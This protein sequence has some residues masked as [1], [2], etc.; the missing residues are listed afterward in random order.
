MDWLTVVVNLVSGTFAGT[1]ASFIATR[2]IERLKAD[3]N[4]EL[5]ESQNRFSIGVNSHQAQIGFDKRAEF[6]ERYMEEALR[7]LNTR[8]A[9]DRFVAFDT[10]RLVEIRHR[11]AIWLPKRDFDEFKVFEE[12]LANAAA[13]TY[14]E[15]QSP[16]PTGAHV[17]RLIG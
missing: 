17:R 9:A 7:I 16:L 13:E 15:D 6:C 1:I 14:G 5:Q 10:A 11:G 12:S 4:K 8:N 3:W 2:R